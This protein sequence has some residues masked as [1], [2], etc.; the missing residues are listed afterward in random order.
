MIDNDI[1]NAKKIR[2]YMKLWDQ[3]SF[4]NVWIIWWSVDMSVPLHGA[5]LYH[6][7]LLWKI[8]ISGGQGRNTEGVFTWS[9]AEIYK[10]ILLAS[11]VPNDIIYLDIL[12]TNTGENVLNSMKIIN[13]NNI[14]FE[15]IMLIHKPYMERRFYAT[16]EQHYPE[17]ASKLIVSSIDDRFD[18]YV[19]RDDIWFELHGIINMLVGD[20]DRIVKYPWLWYQSKQVV[21][22]SV[23]SACEELKLRWYNDFL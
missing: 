6:R 5:D 3:L 16:F 17:L 4:C 7:W 14:V 22:S 18:E 10:N 2:D 1:I 15:K 21:P 11:W 23:L 9:E 12:A 20:L 13:E 19:L 8:V